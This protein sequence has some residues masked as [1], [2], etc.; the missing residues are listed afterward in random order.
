MLLVTTRSIA[1]KYP[2][3]NFPGTELLINIQWFKKSRYSNS[4]TS[5]TINNTELLC[6]LSTLICTG[7]LVNDEFQF[8]ESRLYRN[9][10]IFRSDFLYASRSDTRKAKKPRNEWE[11]GWKSKFSQ[12]EREKMRFRSIWEMRKLRELHI[13]MVENQR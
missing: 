2:P 6:E 5:E 9:Y 8:P 1:F 13:E 11:S 12:R 3:L 7:L 4:V 10:R